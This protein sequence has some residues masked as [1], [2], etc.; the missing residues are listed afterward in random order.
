MRERSN[1]SFD[2][3]CDFEDIMR[4]FTDTYLHIEVAKTI[5]MG[6]GST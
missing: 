1:V 3:L 4:N 2:I 6:Y 5:S